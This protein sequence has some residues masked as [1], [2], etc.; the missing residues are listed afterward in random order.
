MDSPMH[1]YYWPMLTLFLWT[2]AVMLRNVQV[3][4]TSVLKGELTNEYFELFRGAQPSDVVIKTG[5]HLKNLFEFP[6]LFYAILLV[7]AH[8]G[9]TGN[10]IVWLAWLYVA[11]R[12]G[13]GI[14]HLTFN[15]VPLRFALFLLSNIVLL[16]LW[17]SVGVAA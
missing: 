7:A 13:H 1:A 14:V 5:N 10:F 2:F 11:L 4:V 9:T 17:L 16:I 6:L 3:R 8:L 12:I 15:Y